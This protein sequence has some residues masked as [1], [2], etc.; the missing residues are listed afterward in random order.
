MAKTIYFGEFRNG[1]TWT[2]RPYEY[3]SK[4]VAI[5]SIKDMMKGN[6]QGGWSTSKCRVWHYEE[7]G[8]VLDYAGQLR[9]NDHVVNDITEE[10][11]EDWF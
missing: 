8:R 2:E 11:R 4:S 7:S 10:E 3:T 9:F 1:V 5:K 6:H